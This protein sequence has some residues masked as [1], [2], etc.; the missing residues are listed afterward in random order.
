VNSFVSRHHLRH[1]DLM[2]LLAM[3]QPHRPLDAVAS[4]CSLPGKLDGWLGGLQQ[5]LE[6]ARRDSPLLRDRCHEH[7]AAVLP[8]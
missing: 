1:L 2:D 6:A 7:V 5:L 8:V 4:Y 3:Y